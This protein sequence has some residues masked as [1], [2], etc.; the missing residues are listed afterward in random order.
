MAQYFN[1]PSRTFN[2]YLLIPGYS[3]KECRVENESLRTPLVKFWG[4]RTCTFNEHSIGFQQSCRRFQ[5]IKWQWHWQRKAYRSFSV[6]SQLKEVE[7]IK[8]P[9]EFDKAGFVTSDAN[10]RPDQT[11]K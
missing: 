1:E 2:E 6:R 11:L 4:R 8:E 9:K 3:S 10:I 7:M 5:M